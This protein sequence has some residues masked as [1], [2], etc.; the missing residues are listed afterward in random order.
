MQE[1]LRGVLKA[2]DKDDKDEA[3]DWSCSWSEL[4]RKA[5]EEDS[6]DFDAEE[7]RDTEAR[8]MATAITAHV[9]RSLVGNPDITAKRYA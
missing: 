6:R 7:F 9:G 8:K 1:K 3:F 5:K 2:K 4:Q